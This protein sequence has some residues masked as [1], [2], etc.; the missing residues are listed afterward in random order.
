MMQFFQKIIDIVLPPRCLLCGKIISG[1]N[2]GTLFLANKDEEFNLPEF[3][4]NLHK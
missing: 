2:V 4:G 3:V 1:E